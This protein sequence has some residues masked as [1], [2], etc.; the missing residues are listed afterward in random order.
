MNLLK[1]IPSNFGI[2]YEYF[3][4]PLGSVPSNYSESNPDFPIDTHLNKWEIE[5]VYYDRSLNCVLGEIRTPIKNFSKII[6][7]NRDP[8]IPI[9]FI[10]S[11][12]KI[13]RESKPKRWTLPF[14]FHI[15]DKTLDTINRNI[16]KLYDP[17]KDLI[18]KLK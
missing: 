1:S 15:H 12:N 14:Y 2:N 13:G 18:Y 6:S 9:R 11:F 17:I 7:E 8:Y 3:E 4:K 10:F 5:V 16:S